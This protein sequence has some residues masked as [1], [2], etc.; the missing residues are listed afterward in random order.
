MPKTKVSAAKL[1]FRQIVAI[2]IAVALGW[3]A[4][5]NGAVRYF[6]AS[7]PDRGA[8]FW[9]D[10]PAVA[11][12]LALQTLEGDISEGN[13]ATDASMRRIIDYRFADLTAAE[14]YVA[15][16]MQ[17]LSTGDMDG[18]LKASSI[19][20]DRDPGN[21]L[22]LLADARISA[23]AGRV[24]RTLDDLVLLGQIRP[25][26]ISSMSEPL[27]LLADEPE[28]SDDLKVA[29]MQ[30]PV[31][32][33]AVLSSMAKDAANRDHILELAPKAGPSSLY[34]L[35]AQWPQVL[36]ASLIKSGQALEARRLWLL[37]R[38]IDGRADLLLFDPEFRQSDI[39]DDFAWRLASD[40]NGIAD[41]L[42]GGGIEVI[43]YGH[44][45][46]VMAMQTLALAPGRY[47][48]SVAAGAQSGQ[49]EFN[50]EMICF[51]ERNWV[52]D[53]LEMSRQPDKPSQLDFTIEDTCQWQRLQ[54][55]ARA[56][57]LPGQS[58]IRISRVE[59]E[60]RGK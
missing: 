23:L 30:S 39:R 13:Q 16:S 8:L 27:A 15:I 12:R 42:N 48:L 32:A 24:P 17:R 36:I 51:G 58:Q 60:R 21:Y 25:E 33:N 44:A 10:H 41:P 31:I 49:G 37:Q 57:S 7:R 34:N 35:S 4:L 29:M 50:W 26:M 45:D 20:L 46:S 52:L 11:G 56:P 2:L 9:P 47:R 53:S 43:S 6:A 5:A 18:A 14:P 38:Q 3:F 59:I 54:L 55:V 19:A 40:T 22:A 28:A 1:S